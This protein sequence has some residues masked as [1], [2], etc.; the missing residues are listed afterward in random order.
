MLDTERMA[1]KAW[2]KA[3]TEHGYQLDEKAYLRLVGRTVRD[4]EGIF[5]ELFGGDMPFLKVYERR[6]AY[7]DADIADNGI[8]V[9][10]GLLDLLDFLEANEIP[11]AVASSTPGWFAEQKLKRVGIYERF[12]AM[13]CGDQVQQGKPAPDLFLEAARRLGYPPRLCAA[14]EDSEAGILSAYQAGVLP[15]MVPDLKPASPETA[16]L[17]YGIYP[18]LK[19]VIPV[20][21]GFLKEG[22]PIR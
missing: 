10:A 19:E 1:R 17:A 11:K 14:L 8:P 20:F 22:L 5:L 4:A 2:T 6:Q 3:L 13:V 21:E 12:D 9:K 18:S 16:G 15:M 7:Y